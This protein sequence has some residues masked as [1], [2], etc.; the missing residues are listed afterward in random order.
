MTT[1]HNLTNLVTED[2]E[3][4]F[5]TDGYAIVR[6]VFAEH[7]MAQLRTACDRWKFFGE[8][9]G[10]TWR[11]QNTTI[12]VDDD[13]IVGSVVK[14][15][16]WP[17]YHDA[18]FDR[19]RTDSRLQ[20]IV[21]PLLGP[22]VKQIVNHLHWKRP[23]TNVKWDPHRD[24]RSR[25]PSSAF[26]DLQESWVQTAIAVDPHL[27][28]N[29]AMWIVPGSHLDV[30]HNPDDERIWSA[31]DYM[32]DSRRT[33]LTLEPGDVALWTAYTVHGSGAN[34]TRYLDRRLYIN[35]FVKADKCT[36]GEW[37]WRA[38]RTCPL[39]IDQALIQFEDVHQLKGGFYADDSEGQ[40]GRD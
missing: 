23:G 2:V 32:N 28:A 14:A 21:E 26:T 40:L 18:V 13:P 16:A 30:D 6:G 25:R 36:R 10:R 12:V 35:G 3:T 27:E 5:W 34:T 38:G 39:S 33:L 1:N 22:D 15:M 4:K 19:F 8:L 17:S 9:L 11:K 20:A 37:V 24:V 7:E 31:S 29:G